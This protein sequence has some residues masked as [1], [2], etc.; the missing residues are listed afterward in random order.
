MYDLDELAKLS[1]SLFPYFS[2]GGNTIY[3]GCLLC[4]KY[5]AKNFTCIISFYLNNFLMLEMGQLELTTFVELGHKYSPFLLE[6]SHTVTVS[7]R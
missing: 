1:E 5:W 3:L 6:S 2:S 7:I 4:A